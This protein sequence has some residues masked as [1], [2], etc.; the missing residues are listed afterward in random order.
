M[1]QCRHRATR[2]QNVYFLATF[3]AAD[4]ANSSPIFTAGTFLVPRR[5]EWRAS[6]PTEK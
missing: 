4:V 6:D 1:R 2:K 5:H 3:T